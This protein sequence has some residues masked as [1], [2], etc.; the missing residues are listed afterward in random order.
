M[1]Q[2][3]PLQIYFGEGAPNPERG[4]NGIAPGTCA[5]GGMMDNLHS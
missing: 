5:L 2:V 3:S 4:D 1:M